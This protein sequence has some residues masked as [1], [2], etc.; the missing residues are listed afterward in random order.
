MKTQPDRDELVRMVDHVMKT[1][2][3]IVD[4]D[5]LISQLEKHLPGC[6]IG[7]LIF[8]PPDGKRLSAAEIVER[9]LSGKS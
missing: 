8:D 3:C 2:G 6:D 7:R 5:G 1:S 4:V 9:A